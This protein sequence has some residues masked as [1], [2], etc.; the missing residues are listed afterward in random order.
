MPRERDE[1]G[2]VKES[3]SLQ[4]VYSALDTIGPAG[5]QEVA[6]ELGSS[7]ETA[8]QKLRALEDDERV[9]SRKVGNA[10]LWSTNGSA[11]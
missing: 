3:Y 7:Y 5:T 9:N 11:T 8:Y 4:S 10:R 2:R 6:D 1:Q